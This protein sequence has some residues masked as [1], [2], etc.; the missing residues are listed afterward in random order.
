MKRPFHYWLLL[1][2]FFLLSGC[3]EYEEKTREVG[4]KGLAKIDRFLAA[5]RFATGM[6]KEAFSYAGA[7]TLPPPA[8]AS[9]IL[10]AVS[11]QSEGQ[12]SDIADWALAGGNLIVYLDSGEAQWRAGLADE[13]NYETF[14]TYFGFAQVENESFPEDP[15]L[16]EDSEG[17]EEPENNS[18]EQVAEE[19]EESYIFFRSEAYKVD[20]NSP[21][22]ITST[23]LD[24]DEA[25]AVSSYDYGE[26]A[27]R[28]F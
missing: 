18:E 13:E 10:P 12:L 2:L 20:F 22:L 28:N 11:L 5:Q 23:D 27:Q 14:L 16:E 24:D 3:G 1:P 7:P 26:G 6:G 15:F 4:Y 19:E 21:Y 25:G 8:G 9:L 17:D